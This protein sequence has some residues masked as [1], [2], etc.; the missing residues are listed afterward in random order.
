MLTPAH[1]TA[2]LKTY[3]P[4]YT[5][6]FTESLTVDSA[7]VSAIN[8]LTVTATAHGLSAGNRIVI[9]GGMTR[10]PLTEAVLSG[11]TVKFTTLYDHDLIRPS[12]PLDDETLPLAGFAGGATAWNAD[13]E[14]IDVENR[15]NFSINLPGAEVAA[16]AVDESQYLKERIFTGVYTVATVPTADT[17]TLSLSDMPSLPVGTI[18]G[19]TLVKGFNICAVANFQRA[20]AIYTELSSPKA[21][22]FVIMT[23]GVISQDRHTFSD[24]VAAFTQ[25][26]ENLL[27]ALRSFSVVVILPTDDDISG[28]TAQNE[29]YGDLYVAILK[30]LFGYSMTG[31]GI[32][33]KA[34]PKGDGPTAYNTAY[35]GHVYDFELPVTLTYE[36][37]FM[38]DDDV[39]FRDLSMAFSMFANDEYAQVEADIN[40][41]DEAL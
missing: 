32:P 41:D 8:V 31:Q 37:G 40:L 9:T 2:H 24:A 3:L 20:E 4:L 36:D 30:A 29:V 5:D 6:K 33:Y 23:D 10:N 38:P 7:T 11:D 14:I 22:L 16:P 27:T 13:H 12:L 19:L 35:Y 1:I 21:Y 15:R 17:F 26:D 34:V 39:A 18:D 28:A 25:Q